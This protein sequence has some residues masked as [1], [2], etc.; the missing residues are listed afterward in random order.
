MPGAVVDVRVGAGDHVAAGQVLAVVEAMK[1]E[2]PITAPG[3]GV[4][5][6]VRVSVGEAVDAGAALL[7][8]E[9]TETEEVLQ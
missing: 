9:S 4:I 5:T 6:E 7:G 8:W 3:P 1:M 2:H